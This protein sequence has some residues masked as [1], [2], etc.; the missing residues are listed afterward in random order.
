MSTTA[1]Y[2][3]RLAYRF[4]F[5]D[6]ELRGGY[7]IIVAPP[8]AP[9]L[10]TYREAYCQPASDGRPRLTRR[11]LDIDADAR[12]VARRAA[13]KAMTIQLRYYA[14]KARARAALQGPAVLELLD[15]AETLLAGGEVQARGSRLDVIKTMVRVLSRYA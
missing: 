7:T 9:A 8:I 13:V 10:F 12:E 14:G 2:Y 6:G 15:D 5:A 1:H 4:G 11:D 3:H